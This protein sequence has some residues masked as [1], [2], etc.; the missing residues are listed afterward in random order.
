MNP[1]SGTA[2]RV[3]S[4]DKTS[5]FTNPGYPTFER[6]CRVILIARAPAYSFDV[7]RRTES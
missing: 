4:Q 1:T 3:G 2:M 6:M 7:A 5:G